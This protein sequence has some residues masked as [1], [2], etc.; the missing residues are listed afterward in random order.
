[1][2]SWQS[3]LKGV[4]KLHDPRS[5]GHG[6]QSSGVDD[7]N[8]DFEDGIL[9]PVLT[10]SHMM[11]NID[12][13][14]SLVGN[15]PTAMSLTCLI[16]KHIPL[17][18]KQQLVVHRILS[19]ALTCG[20]RPYYFSKDRQILLYIGGEGGVGKSQIIK[21]II[22]GM[23]LINRKDEVIL[24]APTGAAADNIGGNTYHTSL[25]ISINRSQTSTATSRVR[26]LWSDKMI[27]LIDEVS[28]VDLDMISVID[29]QCKIVRCL[30]RNSTTLFGG[31]PIVIFIGDF[32]QFPPVR[33]TP[34]WKQ[35]K[36]PR[37]ED[38]RLL[39]HR[40]KQ[41]IMLNEQIRQSKDP[42]FYDLICR[43]REATLTKDD[44][45]FLN[46]K[47][48]TSLLAHSLDDATNV[49]KRNACRALVNRIRMEEFARNRQ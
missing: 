31:L 26:K 24:M 16:G 49:V 29:N 35:P 4:A 9:E 3:Q 1:L 28:M 21:G 44:L 30:D 11:P 23:D 2:Q 10:T 37:D 43:A 7:F 36:N 12:D 33:G 22:G 17:N 25:G 38:G 14:R 34:L 42:L 19:E 48:I 27:M 45:S 40:F 20:D 6:A 5:L 32:F 47:V 41:V 18:K 15:N 13:S 46:T 39:W 8:C